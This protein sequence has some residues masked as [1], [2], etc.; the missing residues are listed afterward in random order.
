MLN[1]VTDQRADEPDILSS[2]MHEAFEIRSLAGDVL[3]LVV[4]PVEGWT[5]EQLVAV[6]ALHEPITHDG[7]DAYLGGVWVGGT[8]V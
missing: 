2:V 5:H 4:A 8:E 3:K 7:A 6:S 1:L